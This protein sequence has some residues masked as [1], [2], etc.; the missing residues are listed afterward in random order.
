MFGWTGK[1]RSDCD[2]FQRFA[3]CG[4]NS[5]AIE[6]QSFL[7]CYFGPKEWSSRWNFQCWGLEET[8]SPQFQEDFRAY[9]RLCEAG[10]ALI[11]SHFL[12]LSFSLT[13][14]LFCSLVSCLFDWLQDGKPVAVEGTVSLN[15]CVKLLQEHRSLW[16]VDSEGMPI[17][18]VTFSDVLKLLLFLM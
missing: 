11:S 7:Y 16:I 9:F 6:A 5:I 8:L 2:D 4:G 15:K 14:T 1:T 12:F 13:L 10:L 18:L 17:S 3:S